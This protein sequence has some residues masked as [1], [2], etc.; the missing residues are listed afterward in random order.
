M[1]VFAALRVTGALEFGTLAGMLLNLAVFRIDAVGSALGPVH[2]LAYAT[3]FVLTLLV[4]GAP[5]RSRLLALVP[6]VGG[7]LAARSI[8]TA[9]AARG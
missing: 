1:S 5:A 6:G 7:L 3:A 4:P 9:S 8:R 2:G